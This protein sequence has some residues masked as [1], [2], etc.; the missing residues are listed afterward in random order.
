[1]KDVFKRLIDKL[2]PEAG[3]EEAAP[4]QM[5]PTKSEA[6]FKAV[7]KAPVGAAGGTE[8]ATQ[9]RLSDM[10]PRELSV[11]Q[12][13]G[14]VNDA[15]DD[16]FEKHPSPPENPEED[17]PFAGIKV[18]FVPKKK[19]APA[20]IAPPDDGIRIQEELPD[21]TVVTRRFVPQADGAGNVQLKGD[22]EA[23]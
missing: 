14:Y 5:G 12:L 19:A 8:T 11:E 10:A 2:K 17:N 18:P 1:M 9:F 22:S 6:T 4:E 13:D 21:G 23:P 16:F 15:L 3:A 7:G 20:A